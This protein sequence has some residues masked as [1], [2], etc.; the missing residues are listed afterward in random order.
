MQE[1]LASEV[2]AVEKRKNGGAYVPCAVQHTAH[3][4]PR[5]NGLLLYT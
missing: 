4:I 5:T 2:A 3:N 1:R